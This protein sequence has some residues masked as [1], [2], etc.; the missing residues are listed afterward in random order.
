MAE[1]LTIS[2]IGGLIL[3]LAIAIWRVVLL[4]E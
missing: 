2:A 3:L 1:L 4:F